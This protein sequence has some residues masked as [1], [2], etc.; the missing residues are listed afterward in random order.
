MPDGSPYAK[1]LIYHFSN[2][3]SEVTIFWH[4]LHEL[5]WQLAKRFVFRGKAGFYVFPT[6]SYL[7]GTRG[8]EN[9]RCGANLERVIHD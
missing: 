8:T 9:H 5:E 6:I 3:V 2:G 4:V 1:N 7:E